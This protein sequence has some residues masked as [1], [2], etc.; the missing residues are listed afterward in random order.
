MISEGYDFMPPSAEHAMPTKVRMWKLFQPKGPTGCTPRSICVLGCIPAHACMCLRRPIVP[1]AV[2]GPVLSEMLVGCCSV[3]LPFNEAPRRLERGVTSM[4]NL[5][6]A[7]Y[8]SPSPSI[9]AQRVKNWL[10]SPPSSLSFHDTNTTVPGS[11][12]PPKRRPC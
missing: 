9:S 5:S 1:L 6:S 8:V 7:F 10:F 11:G 4:P 2:P 3:W 12:P